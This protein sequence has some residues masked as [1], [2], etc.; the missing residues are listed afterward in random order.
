MANYENLKSAIQQVVKTN[1]NSAITGALLQQSLLA[2]IN[3]LGAGYQ[4]VGIATPAT[5]PGTPDQNVFYIASINGTYSNFNQIVVSNCEFAILKYSGQWQKESFSIPGIENMAYFN[6]WERGFYYDQQGEKKPFSTN[7]YGVIRPIDVSQIIGKKYEILATS[8]QKAYISFVDASNDI[9]AQYQPQNTKI[10]GTIPQGAKYLLI[11]NRFY[12]T[13][14]GAA[15]EYPIVNIEGNYSWYVEELFKS[16]MASIEYITGELEPIMGDIELPVQWVPNTYY[17]SLGVLSTNSSWNSAEI[18]VRQKIGT[19]IRFKLFAQLNSVAYCFIKDVNGQISWSKRLTQAL[20]DDTVRIP[21]NANKLLLSN[22]IKG[23]AGHVFEKTLS[24]LPELLNLSN[25]IKPIKKSLTIIGYF[26]EWE[27]GY[28]YNQALQKIAFSGTAYGILPII[29]VSEFIGKPYTINVGLQSYGYAYVSFADSSN[30]IIAQYRP[31]GIITGTIPQDAKY[32]YITNRFSATSGYYCENPYVLIDNI[33]DLPTLKQLL[34]NISIQRNNLNGK[35]ISFIGD[36]I[37]E[38]VGA[39]PSTKRYSTLFCSYY[40][41]I[42]NNLGVAGTSLATNVYGHADNTRFVTRAT[43]ENLANSSLIVIFGGTNDFSYDSKAIGELFN[44][45]T[46]TAYG[47]IGT[48]KIGA[49]T[50]TDTFAGALHDL[51]NTVRVNCPNVPIVLVTPINRG[52]FTYSDT[53]PASNESNV[54]GDYLADF[55]KAIKTIGAFYSIPVLDTSITEL[56]F[57]NEA[58]ANELSSDNLHPNNKGHE[59]LAKILYRF[60]EDNVIV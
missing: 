14:S 32:L 1:G 8:P 23:G 4:Y 11:T 42:E 55:T 3:S 18:D 39:S 28:Y 34:G 54:N 56:D 36:S 50:D 6:A 44:E 60:V 13:T 57:A 41:A 43:S 9:I 46:I 20:V 35:K 30:T 52:H 58:I 22:K 15:T 40:G 12:V 16:V 48:K 37:T 19:I 5:N 26:G 10:T 25:E 49:I 21:Q 45:T 7:A 31:Q 47:R 24:Y 59:I 33:Y 17:D 27:R 53:L 29:D 2:M 51:I 38:G